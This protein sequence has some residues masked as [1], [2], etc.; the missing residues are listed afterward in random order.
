LQQ[1]II[2]ALINPRHQAYLLA[3][4]NRFMGRWLTHGEGYPDWILRLFHR[5]HGRWDP[6]PV[7]EKVIGVD[8]PGRLQGDLLHESEQGIELYLEKQNRYST[9]QAKAMVA[10]DRKVGARH[11]VIN[12]LLRF[13]KFYFLRLGLLDGLP[14]FVHIVTGAFFTGIKYAK[15]LALRRRQG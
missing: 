14:G 10:S 7:H 4:R 9:T 6:S 2:A 13:G 11:V 8:N 5:D 12:P 15:V 1:S 3:R